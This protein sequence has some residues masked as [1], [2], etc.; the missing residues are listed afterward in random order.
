MGRL[1]QYLGMFVGVGF[2]V[3]MA[4]DLVSFAFSPLPVT[5]FTSP[6][7][8]AAAYAGMYVGVAAYSSIS[9]LKILIAG[10]VGA[11]LGFLFSLRGQRVRTGAVVAGGGIFAMVTFLLRGPLA[12]SIGEI[13]WFVCIV[14]I[15]ATV[16]YLAVRVF[17]RNAA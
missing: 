6:A 13:P 2:V 7:E 15:G 12:Q 10:V 9:I 5:L 8:L 16:T 14:A 11:G 4:L 17:S 1:A 3:L